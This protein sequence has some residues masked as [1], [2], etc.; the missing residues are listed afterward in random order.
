MLRFLLGFCAGVYLVTQN[1][2]FLP[3]YLTKVSAFVNELLTKTAA[4]ARP[5]TGP[6]QERQMAMDRPRE[7]ASESPAV[8]AEARPLLPPPA[9]PLAEESPADR[10]ALRRAHRDQWA[11]VRNMVEKAR[12]VKP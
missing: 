11:E 10:Q 4:A 5:E 7:L 9:P 6:A 3:E 12:E 8:K 1:P 2:G